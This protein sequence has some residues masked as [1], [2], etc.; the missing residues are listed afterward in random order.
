MLNS[1]ARHRPRHDD[2]RTER[3]AGNDPPRRVRTSES[4][5]LGRRAVSPSAMHHTPRR[6]A[7]GTTTRAAASRSNTGAT[8]NLV[9]S[10]IVG[11]RATSGGGIWS[12]GKRQPRAHDRGRQR[13]RP[14]M[15]RRSGPRRGD[16]HR[17]RGGTLINS[18]V[19]GNS[20]AVGG[21]VY[22]SGPLTL[23]NVT[24]AEHRD[25]RR[26]SARPPRGE[27]DALN[28][29]GRKPGRRVPGQPGGGA[30]EYNLADDASCGFGR[31]RRSRRGRP[32]V[33][34]LAATADRRGRTPLHRERGDRRGAHRL[35]TS[36]PAACRAR[37]PMRHRRVRG[38]HRRRRQPPPPPPRRTSELPPP[39]A[40]KSVNVLPKSG[41][42][43]GQARRAAS[44]FRRRSRRDEQLPVGTVVD[45]LKGRVTI[46]AAGGSTADFYGGIFRIGQGKG[47]K[48]LTTLTLVEKLSCPK[49]RQGGAPRP[50]RRSGGCGATAAASSGPRAS[51]ARRPSSAPGGWSRIAASRR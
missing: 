44:R 47:A 19:S 31:D 5:R 45:T 51:T 35:P 2:P 18:T 14:G 22:T 49:A 6:R 15:A 9:D 48:P 24:V 8:L 16:A 39:E 32:H 40:G 43:Q 34:P 13:R 27:R 33:A 28:A 36:R 7:A 4:R 37:E 38:Q 11:N 23:Q 30:E 10:E 29:G 1:G 41:T 46:V 50:R 26:R 42:V 20:A 21:G 12:A 3:R 17:G 25:K